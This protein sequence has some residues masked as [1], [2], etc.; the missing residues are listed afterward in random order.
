MKTRQPKRTEPRRKRP[1]HDRELDRW[2]AELR[3]ADEAD[4]ASGG[5]VDLPPGVPLPEEPGEVVAVFFRRRRG[6]R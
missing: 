2:G 1:L 3:A 4:A 6:G 5:V